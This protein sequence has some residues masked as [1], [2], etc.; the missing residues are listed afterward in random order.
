M[1]TLY[2]WLFTLL[3]A[4]VALLEPSLPYVL[5][6]TL[7]VFYDCVSAW[8]LSRRVAKTYPDKAH[9]WKFTSMKSARV[10]DTLIKG[11]AMIALAHFVTEY[12]A[13]DLVNLT[14]VTTG[15]LVFWQVWSILENESSCRSEQDAKLWKLLQKVMVDKTSRHFDVDLSE[16][17]STTEGNYRDL[18]KE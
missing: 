12:I 8:S 2:R 14:K 1:E 3:G 5:I 17:Q 15:A 9:E 10:L 18:Q 11:Y 16:L 13:G 7:A 4:L 6:Y